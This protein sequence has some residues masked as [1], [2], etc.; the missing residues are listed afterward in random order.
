MEKY[1]KNKFKKFY[2]TV[3]GRAFKAA[4]S[5][6]LVFQ[7]KTFCHTCSSPDF[8]FTVKETETQNS[9]T[10]EVESQPIILK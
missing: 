10:A 3:S 7:V 9:F 1:N 4:T 5:S 8:H 6:P 2:F